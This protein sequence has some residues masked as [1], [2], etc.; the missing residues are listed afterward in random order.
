M[1]IP[2][3]LSASI[4]SEPICHAVGNIGTALLKELVYVQKIVARLIP[5]VRMYLDK[6]KL[7]LDVSHDACEIAGTSSSQLAL[8]LSLCSLLR[9]SLGLE[10]SERFAATGSLDPLGFIGP[11]DDLL[12]KMA[13]AQDLILI[14]SSS[15]GHLFEALD[16]INCLER[17]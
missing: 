2:L 7:C 3:K 9:K 13:A 14:E 10:S 4:A 6:V 5:E 8:A 16:G 17:R 15:F 11:V 1:T 12:I